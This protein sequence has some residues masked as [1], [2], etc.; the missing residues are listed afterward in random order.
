MRVLTPNEGLYVSGGYGNYD[1]SH[2]YQR[3]FWDSFVHTS[4]WAAGIFWSPVMPIVMF[5]G[6]VIELA[7]LGVYYVGY[8][9]YSAGSYAINGIASGGSYAYQTVA[10]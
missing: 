4:G 1:E 9:L 8:G 7:A 5:V 6:G 3:E 2:S 10:G